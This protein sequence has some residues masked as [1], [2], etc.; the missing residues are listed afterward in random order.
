[1]K[2]NDNALNEYGTK[3]SHDKRNKFDRYT[4]RVQAREIS[5]V[6]VGYLPANEANKGLIEFLDG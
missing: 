4:V 3:N 1:M 2:P 6:T 5:Y